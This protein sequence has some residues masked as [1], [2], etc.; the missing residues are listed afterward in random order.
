MTAPVL[1]HVVGQPRAIQQLN[2][3]IATPVHAYLFLGPA[4]TGKREA[5]IAFAAALTCPT[6]GCG[7]CNSCRETLSGRHP[8]VV[9]VERQGASILT[10]QAQEVV[11]LALRTPRAAR[12]QVLILVDFH[13]VEQAAP[14][15]LKTIEE[16]PDTTVILV[17]AENV[18][19]DLV[20][21]ASRCVTVN[22]DPLASA[23]V[24]NV[25]VREGADLASAIAVA[26]VAGGRLDRARLLV[27]EEGFLDRLERW[28]SL[29]SR[30]DGTGATVVLLAEELV[31]AASEPVE[32]VKGRQAVEM[33]GLAAQAER[34]GERAIPG[35][36][37]IEDRHRREQRRVRTDEMRAGL[38]ALAGVYR[39]RLEGSP[40]ASVMSTALRAVELV[41]EAADRLTRNVNDVLLLEWLLLRLD[42]LA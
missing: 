18:P 15:L 16:P 17:L 37:V 7:V 38:A 13:L 35:R 30:L 4:G 1:G 21:I 2:A 40:P 39:G 24:V 3:S 32:A 20:T 9:V 19:P 27:S 10:G 28:R 26:D 14:V 29:P 23:D 34:L 33:A 25:L 8:D 5:A 22:F 36:T 42:S 11:R 31:A 12:F 41:G 6:G